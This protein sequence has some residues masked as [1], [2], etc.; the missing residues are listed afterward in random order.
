MPEI[1]QLLSDAIAEKQYMERRKS[2][3]DVRILAMEERIET[4]RLE[5]ITELKE[6]NTGYFMDRT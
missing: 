3:I 6:K 2:E 4:L 1:V 5:W